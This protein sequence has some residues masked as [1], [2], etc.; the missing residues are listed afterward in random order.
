MKDCIRPFR[1]IGLQN[2]GRSDLEVFF[3]WDQYKN[4]EEKE[5][6]NIKVAM[7]SSALGEDMP[8]A[9]FAGQYLSELN[10]SKENIIDSYKRILASKYS[11][12]AM[13]YRLNRG[14]RDES[15][16]MCVGCISMVD[17]RSG[18]VAYSRDPINK[19][20]NDEG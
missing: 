10:V 19:G 3:L 4:L 6:E 7:R 20:K 1:K 13:T 8:G 16:A 15:I 9:S 5:G 17:A 18:G 12:A 11:P 14:M 2:L